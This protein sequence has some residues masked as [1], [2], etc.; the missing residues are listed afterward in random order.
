MQPEAVFTEAV[1]GVVVG[2]IDKLVTQFQDFAYGQLFT[3][4]AVHRK[5]VGQ[6]L[7]LFI[8]VQMNS[9]L[10]WHSHGAQKQKTPPSKRETTHKLF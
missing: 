10:H 6:Q 4:F 9:T 5:V 7:H 8:V 1:I 2:L 3:V